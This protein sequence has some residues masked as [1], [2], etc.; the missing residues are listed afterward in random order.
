MARAEGG[1]DSGP[2]TGTGDADA[3][4]AVQPPTDAPVETLGT[5]DS[6]MNDTSGPCSPSRVFVTRQTFTGD[7]AA[8]VNGAVSF[9]DTTCQDI[10]ASRQLGGT[11][12]VWLTDSTTTP[13]MHL[14]QSAC[15]YTLLDGTPVAASFAALY[16]ASAV[17]PLLGPIDMAED[18]TV[19]GASGVW[20]GTPV[21]A[22]SSCPVASCTCGDWAS[23]GTNGGLG[24]TASTDDT[25]SLSSDE[26]CTTMGRL[27]CFEQ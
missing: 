16:Q 8:A 21:A 2:E 10:A 13:S 27:Y 15:P 11:W 7:F 22:S 9:G 3:E 6:A 20:T 23:Q 24:S 12:K 26:P 1:A 25:W 4:T 17:A 5:L 18:G 14:R 19:M